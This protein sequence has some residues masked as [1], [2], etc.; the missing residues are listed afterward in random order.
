M[1]PS[2]HQS[3]LQTPKTGKGLTGNMSTR[4]FWLLIIALLSLVV[5]TAGA[6]IYS[7]TIGQAP[8]GNQLV[9]S[10]VTITANGFEPSTITVKKGQAVTWINQDA[11]TH[12]LKADTPDNSPLKDEEVFGQGDEYSVIFEETGTFPYYDSQRTSLQG[13]VVVED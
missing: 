3:P 11:T 2:T 10:Q 13:T 6:L 9:D 12:Q 8:N 1:E 4:K 7:Q 5:L